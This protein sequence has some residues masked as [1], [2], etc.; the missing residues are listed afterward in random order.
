MSDDSIRRAILGAVALSCVWTTSARAGDLV[1][2][3]GGSN[4]VTLVGAVRRW[5]D[6]G[7]PRVP[8]DP[9]ARIDAPRVDASAARDGSGRWV[10]RDLA[11]G[12]YD[13]VV[14]TSGK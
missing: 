13:L 2:A 3:L 11:P 9:K 12:R 1:V 6:D 7:N 14:I 8:V 5:D 4:A 10:F